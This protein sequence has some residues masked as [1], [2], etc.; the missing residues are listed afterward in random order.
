MDVSEFDADGN[1]VRLG[2]LTFCEG[3]L[4]QGEC[5]TVRLARRKQMDKDQSVQI[6]DSQ[7]ETDASTP[8]S[9]DVRFAANR[10]TS[11]FERS[12]SVPSEFLFRGTFSSPSSSP[13]SRSFF[14][15]SRMLSSFTT[16]NSDES[17]NDEELVAVK[18]FNK[19]ILKRM[20]TL[21]RDKD[22]HRV[23]VKTGLE[24]VER[25]IALMKKL[26]HP[27]L[28]RLYDVFDSPE[29]DILCL[30]MEYMPLGEILTYQHDGTFRRKEPK[31]GQ[32][33][34]VRGLVNGH[35]DEEQ[36]ALYFVDILH[37]LAYLHL[38]HICHRD[39][40]PENIL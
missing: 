34:V 9:S 17:E 36:S 8:T 10:R 35:F 3:I 2:D 18:I 23:K 5:G 29:S 14:G 11:D 26:S 33:Q 22:T 16:Q 19:S 1:V 21:E 15:R 28:V 39:I 31:Q 37:G 30:V 7:T 6:S 32:P 24:Q 20:R 13:S 4:G 38:H 25:E 27:N 12:A 40:K